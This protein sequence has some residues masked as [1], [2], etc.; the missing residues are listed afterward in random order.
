[1]FLNKT[2]AIGRLVGRLALVLAVAMLAACAGGPR[3]DPAYV[4]PDFRVLDGWATD[5][6]AAALPALLRSCERF[7]TYSDGRPIGGLTVAGTAGD[8]RPICQAALSVPRGDQIAARQFFERWLTPRLVRPAAYGGGGLITG[9][10]E[11]VLR[12]SFTRTETYSVPLYRMPPRRRGRL[13]SRAQ[14]ERGALSGRGYELIWVDDAIDAFFLQIQGSGRIVLPD[15]NWIGIGYAGQ[16]GHSY[17]P[18]GRFLVEQEIATPETI[19]L[20]VIERWLRQNP[21]LADQVMN[22]NRSYV[23]FRLKGPQGASGAMD[24][25]LTAGRSLAVDPSHVPLGIPLWL[26]ASNAPV[27]GGQLRR[28]VLAQDVGGA[29]KGPMRGDLFWG[30]GE[31]AERAAG[32]MKAR[33]TLTMLVPRSVAVDRTVAA[34]SP[35]G[36]A[37]A[38]D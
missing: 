14:I 28:L 3:T 7:R 23:F 9:Y 35:S 11:P 15:G 26:D 31:V 33:G 13:P 25:E 24:V 16:N 19:S 4:S 27:P 32:G 29:I 8:W 21:H 36:G 5:D 37:S 17:Y 12:G 22:L 2:T 10:Y 18:I 6:H 34:K 38:F 1:M 30:H 20:Q